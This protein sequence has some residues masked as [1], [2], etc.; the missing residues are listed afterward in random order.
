MDEKIEVIEGSELTR[1]KI[2]FRLLYTFLFVIILEILKY[3]VQVIALFQF[4]ILFITKSYSP[5]LRNFS[6]KICNY[7][8]RVMRYVTLNEN[9][10]PFPFAEFPMEADPSEPEVRFD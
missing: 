5:P 3:I 1:K 10:R 7:S 9:A 8:Y 2:A 6:N 4:V